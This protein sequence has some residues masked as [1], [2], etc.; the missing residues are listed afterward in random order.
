MSLVPRGSFFDLDRF[1]DNFGL[2]TTREESAPSG[3]FAPRIDILDQDKQYE[4]TAEMPGVK[5]QDL[6]VTLNNGVLTIEAES[7]QENKEEQQGKLIRQER[8][9]GKFMR[10]FNL[11]DSVQ[12]DDIQA[13]FNDGVLKLTVPKAA[14][15]PSQE[16]RIEIN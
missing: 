4:I 5:K 8:R 1:F 15:P 10:S 14:T 7:R 13:S 12:E 3:F 9:Y 16:R 2:S 6:Q 11:G